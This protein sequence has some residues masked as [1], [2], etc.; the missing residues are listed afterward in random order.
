MEPNEMTTEFVTAL[1]KRV[2][3]A[4]L[5]LKA[6]TA[7]RDELSGFWHA[8]IEEIDRLKDEGGFF[9]AVMREAQ[10]LTAA[11]VVGWRTKLAKQR[12]RR[13]AA[14][15]ELSETMWAYG[16]LSGAQTQ[17][18][19]ERDELSEKLREMARRVWKQ[20]AAR[21]HFAQV[22][23]ESAKGNNEWH[24]RR[25]IEL[26]KRAEDAE[27]ER[28]AL[29]VELEF[30]DAATVERAPAEPFKLTVDLKDNMQRVYFN[31]TSWEEF[32]DRLLIKRGDKIIDE[33][34][35]FE[36]LHTG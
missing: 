8:A 5:K 14:E 2:L 19:I 3:D 31:V 11:E 35:E 10:A 16:D 20:R 6:L 28:D 29:R 12:K 22:F 34:G 25:R 15:A 30:A 26:T 32:S 33:V 23:G 9:A 4:E 7:D 18:E 36:G 27:A 17:L 13:K 21:A 1:W 24:R